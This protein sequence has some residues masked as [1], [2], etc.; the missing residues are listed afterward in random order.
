MFSR[1]V[2]FIFLTNEIDNIK[3]AI[4]KYSSHTLFLCIIF[5]VYFQRKVENLNR[6][7]NYL[8][9]I[10]FSYRNHFEFLRNSQLEILL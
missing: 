10:P 3:F 1:G 2:V 8:L 7:F 4:H 6:L 9:H 5:S